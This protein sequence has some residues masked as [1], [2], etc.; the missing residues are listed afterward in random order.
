MPGRR[1]LQAWR[2]EDSGDLMHIEEGLNEV[3]DQGVA[4]EVILQKAFRFIDPKLQRS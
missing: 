1:D 4:Q 3:R 2:N